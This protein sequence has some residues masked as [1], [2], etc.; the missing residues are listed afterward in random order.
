MQW[1]WFFDGYLKSTWFVGEA[2][3]LQVEDIMEILKYKGIE[4]EFDFDVSTS[5]ESESE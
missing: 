5:D 4:G 1:G 2:T 3:S